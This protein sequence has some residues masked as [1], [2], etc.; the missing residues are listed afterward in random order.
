MT[1]HFTLGRGEAREA[2]EVG[3]PDEGPTPAASAATPPKEGIFSR[4]QRR[5]VS[6][7]RRASV[8]FAALP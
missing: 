2:L 5:G 7:L 3:R 8:T 1:A 6:I 4:R